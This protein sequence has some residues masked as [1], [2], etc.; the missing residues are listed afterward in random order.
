MD[1]S[2][3]VL[4]DLLRF[5]PL[6]EQRLLGNDID[7]SDTLQLTHL[8]QSVEMLESMAAKCESAL[9][10]EEAS[11]IRKRISVV[12]ETLDVL[13]LRSSPARSTSQ[14]RDVMLLPG[15]DTAPEECDIDYARCLNMSNE[16][17]DAL[18]EEWAE[19]RER[20]PATVKPKK[21]GRMSSDVAEEQ[22]RIDLVKLADTMKSKALWY[23]DLLVKDNEALSK[24]TAEQEKQLDTV[25]HAANEA[26]TLAKTARLSLRQSLFMIASLFVAVVFMMM[27]FIIT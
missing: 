23:R 26:A 7:V 5:L 20:P 13:A 15:S 11:A 19:D 2:K 14:Y 22:I 27:V 6:V 18:I 25:T 21:K 17:F 1:S 8:R 4:I 3:A 9:S 16:E 12:R 24:Y 10:A